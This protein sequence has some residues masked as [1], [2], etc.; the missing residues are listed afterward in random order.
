MQ[1]WQLMPQSAVINN[2]PRPGYVANRRPVFNR[3]RGSRVFPHSK[4]GE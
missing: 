3:Y 1:M 2:T 4:Y